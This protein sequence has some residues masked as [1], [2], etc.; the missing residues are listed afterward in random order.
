MLEVDEAV[1]Y[2]YYVVDAEDEGVKDARR[3]QLEASMEVV[4]LCECEEDEP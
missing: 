2:G 3:D 1:E 4:E